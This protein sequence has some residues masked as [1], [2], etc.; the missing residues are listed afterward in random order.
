MSKKNEALPK[1]DSNALT[2]SQNLVAQ[3]IARINATPDR[4]ISFET[5]MQMALYE[6]G[7]GYYAAGSQKFG[8]AG[9][10]VTAPEISPLFGQVFSN[11]IGQIL[12]QLNQSKKCI[13]ELG[14]GTGKLAYDI[15]AQF[16]P[17]ALDAY[18]IL[19]VSPDL[20]AR[21]R[22]FLQ[23]KLTCD[24]FEKIQW[25][26]TLPSS[27]EGVI[28]A[29]EVLD[30]VPFSLIEWH[31]NVIYERGVSF[32]ED[33]FVFMTKQ[34]DEKNADLFQQA[35]YLAEK[36]NLKESVPYISEINILSGYLVKSL[37]DIL[38]KGV[39]FLIDYGFNESE[40]YHPERNTGTMMCHYRHF[41]H[42]DPFLYVGL[43]DMTAHVDFSFIANVGY[44]R[45]LIPLSFHTQAQFLIAGEITQYL[46]QHQI[47]QKNQ[48]NSDYL[49]FQL[50]NGVQKLLSPSEMGELF[51][52]LTLGKNLPDHFELSI[53]HGRNQLHKL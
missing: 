47:A 43:Q 21:Q 17:L 35:R 7:L 26:D 46:Q 41:A 36:T 18:F 22:Q 25:L 6:Q 52:V 31:E 15:L 1:P 28:L 39:I 53:L 42:D 29:N 2:Q 45:G 51:K 10:F 38:K 24:R 23:E 50:V 40:F 13:L 9:D 3:I 8:Q 14:A 27:F 44:E 30:A 5:F 49:Y 34:I 20:Q 12:G 19:E 37:A 33:Q 4:W 48:P 16:D 11:L 32:R